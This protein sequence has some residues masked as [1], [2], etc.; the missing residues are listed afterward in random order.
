[1]IDWANLPSHQL[2][3][4]IAILLSPKDACHTL[5]AQAHRFSYQEPNRGLSGL[6]T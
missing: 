2:T 5:S 1:M 6:K 4:P 3:K